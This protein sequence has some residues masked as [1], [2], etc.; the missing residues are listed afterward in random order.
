MKH[1]PVCFSRA[2]WQCGILMP[3]SIIL[4]LFFYFSFHSKTFSKGCRGHGT[5]GHVSWSRFQLGLQKQMGT[6]VVMCKTSI[7]QHIVFN[8]SLVYPPRRSWFLPPESR[9]EWQCALGHGRHGA[10]L[11]ASGGG[12][13]AEPDRCAL[14]AVD[15]WWWLSAT[16]GKR[17]SQQ[18]K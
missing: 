7:C 13:T 3:Y 12:P 2:Q 10:S 15:R 8:K 1:L 14:P 11:R 6:F 17:C 16:E 5:A 9:G 18:G 4:F